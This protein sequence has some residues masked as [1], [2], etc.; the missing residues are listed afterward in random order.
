MND[1]Q[2][3]NYYLTIP[4]ATTTKSSWIYPK[5]VKITGRS[6]CYPHPHRYLNLDEF[7]DV[8]DDFKH[9]NPKLSS[10]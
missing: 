3:Y 7:L 10:I 4:L 5:Y 9:E 2:P 1:I 8:I 6:I